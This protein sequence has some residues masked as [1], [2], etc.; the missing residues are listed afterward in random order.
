MSPFEVLED[1]SVEW[2]YFQE[3]PDTGYDSTVNG[4]T[5]EV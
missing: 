3:Y 5:A 1:C 4:V 2:D